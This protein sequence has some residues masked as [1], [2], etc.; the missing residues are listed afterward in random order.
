MHVANS[1]I[2][3]EDTA[4][5]ARRA[6]IIANYIPPSLASAASINLAAGT[7]LLPRCMNS[8][9]SSPN[10]EKW[11]H[12]KFVDSDPFPWLLARPPMR[13]PPLGPLF[14]PTNSVYRFPYSPG[15][16]AVIAGDR[17]SRYFAHRSGPRFSC[18][19]QIRRGDP[20]K[21]TRA[22]GKSRIATPFAKNRRK[23]PTWRSAILAA[24]G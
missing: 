6:P 11:A 14:T 21:H 5:M 16:A 22:G 8:A 7:H 18:F 4:P 19:Q 17:C 12:L 9:E 23:R 1:A 15:A 10:R 3:Q 2:Q 20:S 13:A 24:V